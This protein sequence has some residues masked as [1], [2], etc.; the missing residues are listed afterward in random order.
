M[1]KIIAL[2]TLFNPDAKVRTNVKTI[3]E[4]V[5]Y[6]YLCDNSVISNHSLFCDISNSSYLFE[7]VNNGISKA[8]NT[9]LKKK[10]KKFSD[11]DFIIFFDQDSRISEGY[12]R[13]LIQEYKRLEEQNLT[14]GCIGPIFQNSSNNK[15]EVPR[16]KKKLSP[17]SYQVD[18]I[19]TSSMLTR[20][21]NLLDVNFWNEDIFLDFTDWD[22]CWR[23]QQSQKICVIT[24]KVVLYHAVGIGNKKIGFYDIR[25]G[26]P[27]REY[28]QIRDALYLLKEDYVPFKMRIKLLQFAFW[29]PFVHCLFLDNKKE[30]KNYIKQAYKDYDKRIHGCIQ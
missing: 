16:I 5:D 3:A 22:L 25:V 21:S 13:K 8:F 17:C 23:L 18:G 14:I 11:N 1:D 9:V 28:Y 7:G 4:Q 27:I 19:I 10:D 15:V 30:R 2:I 29:L 20:Y 6:V 12:I 26:Q 24:S